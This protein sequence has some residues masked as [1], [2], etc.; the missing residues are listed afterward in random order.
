MQT[1]TRR[2]S[3]KLRTSKILTSRMEVNDQFIS[4]FSNDSLDLFPNN[5]SSCF[6]NQLAREIVA[7][8]YVHEIGLA[9]ISLLVNIPKPTV[10]SPPTVAVSD[11]VAVSDDQKRFFPS[12]SESLTVYQTRLV[13]L[14]VVKN[15]DWP[16]YIA[17]NE[18][19]RSL[20]NRNLDFVI[21]TV[22]KDSKRASSIIKWKDD[23][24]QKTATLPQKLALALG[25]TKYHFE[26]GTY[27]SDQ[28]QSV[29]I[30][31]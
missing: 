28:D 3:S 24:S 26:P 6:T 21:L 13:E 30:Y 14:T 19:N 29:E 5:T 8:K 31:D 4:V 16:I 11:N 18:I 17:V 25:F 12:G 15:K 7:S 22:Q 20:R 10:S 9:Q 2:R 23:I 27:N 1:F